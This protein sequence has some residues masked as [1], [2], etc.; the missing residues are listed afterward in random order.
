M[1]RLVLTNAIYFKGDWTEPFKKEATQE[2]P[3]HLSREQRTTVPLMHRTD[4]FR[5]AAVD[6]LQILELPYGQ[7]GHLSM[8]VLLPKAVDGLPQMEKKLSSENL[9]TWLAGLRSREVRV[10]LPRFKM[11]SQFQLKDVLESMGMT[12]AFTP[13]AADFS[14]LSSE[15]ELFLSAV[16][17]K[18]FVDVN[19]EGTEAAAATAATVALTAAPVAQE[20]AVFRADHPFVFLIRDN[21]T[22]SI[23]FL[24][25]L[26]NP[27]S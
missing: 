18:A 25:R 27:K 22:Q 12:S 3:F 20:P 10:F 7:Q 4:D 2:A 17:H 19:E 23:L 5:Y 6:D 13:G 24:G 21:R 14:R 9:Q 11:T 16:I 1:T 26:M 15:G 8:V